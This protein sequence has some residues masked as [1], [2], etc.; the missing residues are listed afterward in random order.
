MDLREGWFELIIPLTEVV[1]KALETLGE[2]GKSLLPS[3][4]NILQDI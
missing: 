3:M 1:K 2:E 4:V